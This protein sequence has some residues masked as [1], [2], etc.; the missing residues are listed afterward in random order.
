VGTLLSGINLITT[1]VKMR[2]PGMSLMKMPVFT[3]TAL[4]TNALIVVAFP[5]LTAYFAQTGKLSVAAFAAAAAGYALSFAQRMLSTPA[6]LLRRRS[7][8]VSGL[9]TLNDGSQVELDRSALLGP[10]ERALSALS[11]GVVVLSLGLVASR[12]P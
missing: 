11:W 12:L 10:L 1:I 5:V 3:W 6:R 7:R 8:S 9:L 4:C 2:A